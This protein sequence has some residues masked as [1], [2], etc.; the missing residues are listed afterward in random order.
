MLVDRPPAGPG[1][2]HEVKH[3]GFRILVRKLGERAKVWSRCGANF[4]DRFS[5]IA[6][7]VRS[8][9]RSRVHAVNER[10]GLLAWRQGC[11]ERL[12]NL[13]EGRLDETLVDLAAVG[14]CGSGLHYY[15]DGGI[16]SFASTECPRGRVRTPWRTRPR[17]RRPAPS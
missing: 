3:D 8:R 10:S 2:L 13:R 1:W 17:P 11:E 4:T 12:L 9:F 5:A 14:I 15:K 6:A 16:G 7:A